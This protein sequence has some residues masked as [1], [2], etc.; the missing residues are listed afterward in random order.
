VEKEHNHF[1]T[2]VAYRAIILT[3]GKRMARVGQEEKDACITVLL[4]RWL[5]RRPGSRAGKDETAFGERS[6]HYC[7]IITSKWIDPL[8]SEKNIEWARDF[9]EA[10]QPFISEAVYVN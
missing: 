1:R 3:A 4:S 6:A 7:L 10:M 5:H 2:Y 9:W 8:E